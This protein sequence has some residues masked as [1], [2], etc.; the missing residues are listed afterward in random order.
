[1]AS[2]ASV[3]IFPGPHARHQPPQVLGLERGLIA[4]VRDEQRREALAE[5]AAARELHLEREALALVH[6]HRPGQ[7]H[8]LAERL[9]RQVLLVTR[10]PGFMNGAEQ[11]LKQVVLAVAG[12]QAHV[13][14]HAAAE[15]MRALVQPA[16]REIEAERLH[17][18]ATEGAL[19]GDGE[20]PGRLD[21][22]RLCRLL[23]DDAAHRVRQPLLQGVEQR[24]DPR[25]R[26]A[27][28]VLVDERVVGRDALVLGQPLRRLANQCQERLE[29]GGEAG[30][31]VGRALRAPGVL[32][33][34]RGE[35]APLDERLGQGI[36]AAP[37]PAHLAQVRAGAVGE[38]LA[39]GALHR[40][41]QRRLGAQAVDQRLELGQRRRARLVAGGRH[42]ARAVP[43]GDRAEVRQ[44]MQP[45]PV[46][47]EPV[48]GRRRRCGAFHQCAKC[49]GKTHTASNVQT[50]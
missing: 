30:P 50:R 41:A 25:A 43:I 27:G 21:R 45:E 14:R 28:L 7:G 35:R 3:R 23:R 39:L 32:A 6:G 40:V 17:R 18:G 48:V 19:R 1:V 20:R 34:H 33:A 9:A 46:P 5:G 4:D 24:V 22:R 44:A 47:L 49:S 36:G 8:R 16:G 37:L 26:H 42:Q 13:L 2:S 31:V 10:V 38:P 15:R 12:R 11:P 29:V